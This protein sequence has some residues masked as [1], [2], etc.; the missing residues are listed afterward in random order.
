MGEKALKTRFHLIVGFVIAAGLGAIA[1][2]DW[3]LGG[4]LPLWQLYFLPI[5]VAGTVWELRGGIIAGVTASLLLGLISPAGKQ[6]SLETLLGWQLALVFWGGLVGYL[7]GQARSLREV[8]E[9]L[10]RQQELRDSMMDFLVHDLRSPLTNVIS[11]LETLLFTTEERLT[12]EDREMLEMALIGAHR[13]LTMINS[14]LD[15]RKMEDGKFPLYLKEFDPKD[16]VEEATRQIQLWA[17]QNGVTL[18]TKVA[19]EVPLL[20]ADRWVLIRVLVNL[21]SNALKYTPSGKTVSVHVFPDKGWLH[22]SV[23]DEGPGIPREYLDRLFDPF[24]QIEARKGGAAIGTGLGLTFCKLAV[25][26][27]GGRIWLESEVGKGT[28]VHFVIP[29]KTSMPAAVPSETAVHS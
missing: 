18:Q 1:A 21:L 8:N 12:L 9:R 11:G 29:L 15:L 22:F 5:G 23:A 27:H 24:V 28:I 19:E 13:L 4:A 20:T 14:I 6:L 7:K 16:A 25:E 17:R 3:Q 26:A 2:R 10:R